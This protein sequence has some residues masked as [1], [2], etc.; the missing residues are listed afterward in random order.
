MVPLRV[1]Q[2]ASGEG[3]KAERNERTVVVEVGVEA[4]VEPVC[5]SCHWIPSDREPGDE[6]VAVVRDLLIEDV[7]VCDAGDAGGDAGTVG[8][9]STFEVVERSAHDVKREAVGIIAAGNPVDRDRK[10]R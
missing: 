2:R 4:D 1:V 8:S 3:E 6:V 10:R 5:E 9:R 7:T